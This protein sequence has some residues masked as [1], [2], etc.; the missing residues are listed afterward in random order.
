MNSQPDD[1]GRASVP[2]EPVLT[3]SPNQI[4]FAEQIRPR[5]HAEF[6]RVAK[7]FRA[8]ACNQEERNRTDTRAILEILEEKRNEVMGRNEAGYFIRDW[9]ELKDQVRQMI[10]QDSRYR[11]IQAKRGKT[12]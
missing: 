10:G 3:G 5:V 8:V 12:A 6:D 1:R 7:A 11:A 9:Q 4:E 2:N